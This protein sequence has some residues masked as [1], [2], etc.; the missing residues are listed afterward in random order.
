MGARPSRLILLRGD[1]RYGRDRTRARLVPA[2]PMARAVATRGERRGAG[3]ASATRQGTPHEWLEAATRE[4]QVLRR[5]TVVRAPLSTTGRRDRGGPSARRA[6][7]RRGQAPWGAASDFETRAAPAQYT[8]KRSSAVLVLLAV[9]HAGR[10]LPVPTRRSHQQLRGHPRL[11]DP[12]AGPWT[13]ICTLRSV[14]STG[15]PGLMARAA[16]GSGSL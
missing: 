14:V 6:W 1:D 10:Q 11:L 3:G 15:R 12:P 8:V 9:D 13:T 2:L 16:L 5:A 4:G 7:H